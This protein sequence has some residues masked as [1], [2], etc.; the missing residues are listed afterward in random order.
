M[1]WSRSLDLY[2]ER[3]TGDFWAEPI[4]AISNLGFI[5][6]GC[7]GFYLYSRNRSHWLLSLSLLACLVGVGSF[8]F[9]TY[10]QAWSHLADIVPIA[11]FMTTFMA[12]CARRIFNRDLILTTMILIGFVAVSVALERYQPRHLLNGSLGYAHAVLA[13]GVMSFWFKPFRRLTAV[14]LVALVFRTL[15]HQVCPLFSTGT[16]FLWHLSNA[17]L[18]FLI[19]KIVS[20]SLRHQNI[21]GARS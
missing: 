5:L 9:H 8:L 13:L 3:L 20:R 15:D 14:F 2:C 1:D 10:A 16:H 21:P 18:M 11:I 12:F 19:L 6:V 7:Y 17:Y 4:N